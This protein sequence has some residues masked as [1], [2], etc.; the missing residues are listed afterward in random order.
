MYDYTLIMF[1]FR[2]QQTANESLDHVANIGSTIV[3]DAAVL[4]RDADRNVHYFCADNISD[5]DHPAVGLVD[6][7]LIGLLGGVG[8]TL[9]G[10]IAHGA[11][12]DVL[13]PQFVP[14]IP[15][16]ELE[17][18]ANVLPRYSAALVLLV[19][20]I[21]Y[22]DMIEFILPNDPYDIY[23]I[24]IDSDLSYEIH[25]QRFPIYRN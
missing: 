8:S 22:D 14:S 11:M 2:N 17:H 13:A 23:T 16:Y 25:E 24:R 19:E 7:A 10:A 3:A 9:V 6:G 12:D 1:R 5:T 21:Y 4:Y 20:D 18:L 15:R